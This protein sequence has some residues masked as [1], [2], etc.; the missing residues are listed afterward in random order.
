MRFLQTQRQIKQ[1]LFPSAIEVADI[2]RVH[3][4][5]AALTRNRRADLLFH[6]GDICPIDLTTQT[7]TNR[8]V[9]STH[10]RCHGYREP[11]STS[12]VDGANFNVAISSSG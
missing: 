7:D 6:S 8:S 4:H 2:G 5:R 3:R 12:C 1:Q 11:S 9:I 10:L